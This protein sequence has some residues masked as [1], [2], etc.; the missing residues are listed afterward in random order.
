MFQRLVKHNYWKH[1]QLH[2]DL[3][4]AACP[5]APAAASCAAWP[6]AT[7][8]RSTSSSTATPTATRNIYRTLKVGRGNAAH[9]NEYFCVP[10]AHFLGITPQDIIDYELPTHPLKDVDIKRAKDALKNDPFILHYKPWQ[11]ALRADDQDGR[12]RRAAGPG[13]AR[14]ELR[15]RRVPAAERWRTRRLFSPD[16]Q[17][18][19]RTAPCHDEAPASSETGAWSCRSR[20]PDQ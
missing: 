8:C 9:L 18:V 2:P 11:Q 4:W 7:D 16:R 15:D 13:Q 1:G 12:A 5:P 3:A 17:S 6:T 20:R 14:P 10:Q 19:L